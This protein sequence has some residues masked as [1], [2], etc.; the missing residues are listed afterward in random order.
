MSENQTTPPS[1]DGPPAPRAVEPGAVV[2]WA[3]YD[4]DGCRW[5]LHWHHDKA[6]EEC[7]S[8]NAASGQ[9]ER[10]PWRVRPLVYGDGAGGG[11]EA[12]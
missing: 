11:K 3:T 9:D 5:G 12:T 10:K 1:G 2:A 4:A 7:A 8:L 6:V